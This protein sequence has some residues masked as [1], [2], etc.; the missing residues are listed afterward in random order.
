VKALVRY[1]VRDLGKNLAQL[2]KLKKLN[3]FLQVYFFRYYNII[4]RIEIDDSFSKILGKLKVKTNKEIK[5]KTTEKENEII[6]YL[7]QTYNVVEKLT[8]N[9]SDNVQKIDRER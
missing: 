2:K 9:F 7:G 6:E 4:K 1:D 3:D 8:D 5:T